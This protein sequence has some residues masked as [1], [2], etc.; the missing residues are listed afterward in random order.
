MKIWLFQVCD[1]CTAIHFI[2]QRQ[3][4]HY[5]GYRK[6]KAQVRLVIGESK[7]RRIQRGRV[8]NIYTSNQ[9]DTAWNSGYYD[10]LEFK[11]KTLEREDSYHKQFVFV[12][13]R[14]QMPSLYFVILIKKRTEILT[15]A[16]WEELGQSASIFIWF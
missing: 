11:G 10:G 6:E 2:Y 15:K 13:G 3:Y 4:G 5:I 14:E 9:R 8:Q 16:N 1:P 7:G 12:I